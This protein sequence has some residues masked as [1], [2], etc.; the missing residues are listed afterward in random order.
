[1]NLPKKFPLFIRNLAKQVAGFLWKKGSLLIVISAISQLQAQTAFCPS[2]INFENGNFAGWYLYTGVCCP[3]QI[4][5]YTGP[6]TDRHTLKSGMGYD[7]YGAFRLVDPEGGQYSLKIGNEGSGSMAESAVYYFRVPNNLNNY[8][9]QLRYAV[10]LE[11]PDHTATNQPRFE[12][13]GYDSATQKAISC[14][15]FS[16]VASSSIPGFTIS[17]KDPSV[18]YKDWSTA[19]IELSGLAGKTIAINFSTGDC[20]LGAHF[21]YAYVDLNCEMIK[22]E[23]EACSGLSI[24][25]LKGP[26]GFKYYYWYD[27][28]FSKFLGEGKELVI[29]TPPNNTVYQVVLHPFPG[30]GCMDTLMASIIVS[31]MSMKM[32]PDTAVCAG[33]KVQLFSD[34][35]TLT[36]YLPVNYRWTPHEGLSC[37]D[38]PSPKANPNKSTKYILTVKDKTGCTLHDSMDFTVKL[39]TDTNPRDNIICVG[40]EA[41]FSHITGG[42]GPFSYQWYKNGLSVP[43]ETNAFLRIETTQFKDTLDTYMVSVDNGI[44][45]GIL[46]NPVRVKLFPLPQ[47]NFADSQVLCEGSMIRVKGFKHYLWSTGSILDKIYIKEN[48]LYSL[49]V[50]DENACS[51]SDSSFVKVLSLPKVFAGSDT[52]VCGGKLL[53]LN[54]TASIYD[55]V[56]WTANTFGD[57]SARD[58]LR[59]TFA[60]PDREIGTKVLSLYA[61]NGCG[62]VKDMIEV[63]FKRK[64]PTA[65]DAEDTVVCEGSAPIKLNADNSG[66]SFFGQYVTGEYFDPKAGGLYSVYYGKSEDG[67]SDT[68]EQ[69]IRVVFMPESSFTSDPLEISIDDQVYFSAT[70]KHTKQCQWKINLAEKS[71]EKNLRYQFSKAG[72]YVVTLVSLNEMCV[73]ESTQN[74]MVSGSRKLWVPDVFTPNGDGTND[75]FKVVYSNTK[76]GLLTIYDRWG[77]CVYPS[78]DLSKGWDGTFE[79]LPCQ[80]DVYVF[81]VDY[82]VNKNVVKQ[83]TGNVTL[84]R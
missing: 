63:V 39:Y 34:V 43:G 72:N 64:I 75:V 46:S 31:D 44:C 5:D 53:Y 79:G 16:F 27:S 51:N 8:G 59:S 76:G 1:M 26:P 10:V 25:K 77:K 84:L 82:N 29:P 15:Q 36:D 62:I 73:S 21:G 61:K 14:V 22:L 81:I 54:G 33:E 48:G 2:N 41:Y 7:E 6:V 30:F 28:S 45:N 47:L 49:K 67:C 68:S 78:S 19:N 56:W 38:C 32:N 24:S 57:F 65:F 55:S 17:K 50:Y 74:I 12:V 83:V 23:S 70:S 69:K 13:R 58:S 60:L 80:S 18:I 35:K 37:Y 9:L 4:K 42:I 40:E 20:G 71:S 3:I 11:N 66:G 52:F